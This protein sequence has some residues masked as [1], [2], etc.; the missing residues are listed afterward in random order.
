VTVHAVNDAFSM[1]I[2]PDAGALVLTQS[3]SGGDRGR[4]EIAFLADVLE[5]AGAIEVAIADDPA[6]GELLLGARRNVLV[7]MDRL[8]TTLIDDVCVPRTR[9]ADLVAGVERVA[10]EAGLVIGI[11]GHAGDGNFHPTVV[12]DGADPEQVKT[13]QWAFERIME[14]SL[15]LGGTITGEHGVGLLKT[16]LLRRELGELSIDVHRRIKS[17]LDPLGIL[18]PG[19]VFAGR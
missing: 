6:E 7:A 2:S 15:E 18:N 12:F 10:E 11:V 16:D 9:L 4:E 14:I 8:G 5:R 1:G 3:D 17:A 13:A 19:K